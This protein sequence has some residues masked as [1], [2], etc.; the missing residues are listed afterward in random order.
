MP[1]QNREPQNE[2]SNSSARHSEVEDLQPPD[3]GEARAAQLKA[4]QLISRLSPD[5]IEAGGE[6]IR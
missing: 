1:D 6:N 5:K 3:A 2:L 4:G